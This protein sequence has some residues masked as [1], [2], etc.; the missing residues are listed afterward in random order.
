M[1]YVDRGFVRKSIMYSKLVVLKTKERA[2]HHNNN[3]NICTEVA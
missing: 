1:L 2:S 3:N